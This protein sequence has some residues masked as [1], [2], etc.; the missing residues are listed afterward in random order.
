[1]QYGVWIVFGLL[2][3]AALLLAILYKKKSA[4]ALQRKAQGASERQVRPMISSEGEKTEEKKSTLD[5]PSAIE[6]YQPLIDSLKDPF[7]LRDLY[8]LAREKDFPHPHLTITYLQHAG[9]LVPA[10][11]GAY[12]WKPDGV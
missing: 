5:I 8:Q 3:L 9:I 4:A 10:G 11:E 1:M 7:E 12:H 2:A 6:R